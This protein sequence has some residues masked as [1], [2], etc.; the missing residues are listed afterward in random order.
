MG[1][2]KTTHIAPV[3]GDEG[4]DWGELRASTDL[5][6]LLVWRNLALRYKQTLI[7]AGWAVLQPLTTMIILSFVF[8]RLARLPSDG[9]PYPIFYYS[10]L[11]PWMYFSSALSAATNSIADHQRVIT[12]VYFPRVLLPTAAILA[13]LV[14]F[15]VAFVAL[16]PLLLL[17]GVRPTAALFAVPLFA[18]VAAAA[19]LGVGLFFAALNARYRDLRYVLQFLLTLWMFVSPV[20]YPASLVP[21]HWQWLYGLNPLAGAI[22]GFRWAVSGST[23]PSLLLLVA[24]AA[25]A[26]VLVVAGARYF[27]RIDPDMADFV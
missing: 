12:R 2:A 27:Q 9:L 8:G 17:Y 26:T 19:A 21:W 23:P 16:L 22:E 13:A 3:T 18:A 10:G 4:I 20:T 14:D 6:Y 5:L 11:L 25:S 1:A 24:S 15:A 7:G